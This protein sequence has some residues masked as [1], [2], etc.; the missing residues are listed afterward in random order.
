V[1]YCPKQYFYEGYNAQ[2]DAFS[3]LVGVAAVPA[4]SS[5]RYYAGV[6]DGPEVPPHIGSAA[7]FFVP[8]DLAASIDMIVGLSDLERDRFRRS[9][10]WLNEVNA[11][12]SFS[13]RL[14]FE[15]HAIESL[16]PSQS[17]AACKE[18]GR[19]TGPG[20]TALFKSFLDKFAP[21]V[22][23]DAVTSSDLYKARSSATH[24]SGLFLVD[25]DEM[26]DFTPKLSE[27]R[28]QSEAGFYRSMKAIHGWLHAPSKQREASEVDGGADQ[29][30]DHA[31]AAPSAAGWIGR[32]PLLYVAALLALVLLLMLIRWWRL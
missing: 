32:G 29:V 24:G 26:G 3:P 5:E 4:L 18:C 1:A 10:Y 31:D 11:S 14:L 22:G 30:T 6:G 13:V 17:R 25:V 7:S 20:P 19:P 9:C 15:V 12:S 21:A 16:V 8:E 2:P 27:Q 23:S 28:R